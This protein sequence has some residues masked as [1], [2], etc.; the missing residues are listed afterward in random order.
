MLSKRAI[1]LAAASLALG[2]AALTSAMANYD[3]CLRDI[4]RQL[5]VRATTTLISLI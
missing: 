4:L 1:A 2:F 5:V 3:R